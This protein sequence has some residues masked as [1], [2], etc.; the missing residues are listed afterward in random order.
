M[1]IKDRL[2]VTGPQSAAVLTAIEEGLAD[3]R[4]LWVTLFDAA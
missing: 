3:S 4:I 1:N 2:V